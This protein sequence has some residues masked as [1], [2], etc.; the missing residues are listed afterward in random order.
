[1]DDVYF[2]GAPRPTL[3]DI[4]THTFIGEIVAPPI[5]S[6][7]KQATSRFGNPTDHFNRLQVRLYRGVL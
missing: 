3:L 1:V 6:P 7:L 5:D 2:F 4:W